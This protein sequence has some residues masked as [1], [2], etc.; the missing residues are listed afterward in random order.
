MTPSIYNPLWWLGGLKLPASGDVLQDYHPLTNWFSPQVTVN[1][2]GDAD[3]EREIAGQVASPGKQLGKVLE[4]LLPIAA[5]A[6]NLVDQSLKDMDPD[7]KARAKTEFD[8]ALK[9]LR[10]I[11]EGIEKVKAEVK[12]TPLDQAK[13][14]LDSLRAENRRQYD[15]LIRH[16]YEELD[17]ISAD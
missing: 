17:G 11:R 3:I 16:R 14:G 1:Y 13:S 10:E 2:Q 12:G 8:K 7:D 15:R 9:A 4:V 6:G 5:G